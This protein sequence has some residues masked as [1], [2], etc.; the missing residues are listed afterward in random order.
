[1]RRRPARPRPLE[2]W[3]K[4][5]CAWGQELLIGGYTDPA[6]TRTNFG[7]LLVGYYEDGRL[8]YAGKVGTGYRAETLR[9]DKGAGPISRSWEPS[10]ATPPE[11]SS[12]RSRASAASPPTAYS[13]L[14]GS[15]S[16]ESTARREVPFSNLT[17]FSGKALWM[18]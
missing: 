3:L 2:D 10:T 16:S 6:R 17:V 15:H 12:P 14:R 4:L 8:P 7:A 1:V 9:D 11:P 18:L 13:C 5:K